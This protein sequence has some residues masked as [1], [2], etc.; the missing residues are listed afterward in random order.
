MLQHEVTDK[1]HIHNSSAEQEHPDSH[2]KIEV[3]FTKGL[4]VTFHFA[5]YA[6]VFFEKTCLLIKIAKHKIKY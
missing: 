5:N 4:D 2:I 3:N 1:F 6:Q